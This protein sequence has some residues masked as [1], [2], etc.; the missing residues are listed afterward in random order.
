MTGRDVPAVVLLHALSLD[1]SMWDE[2]RRT[3][4]AR[5][6]QVLAPNQRGFGAVPL[7]DD[8]PSLD[9]LAD[10]LARLLDEHGIG[11]AVVVGASMGGYVAMAFLRRHPD[12]V[13]GLALLSTRATADDPGALAQREAFATLVV[14]PRAGPELVDAA[15]AKLV[16]VTTRTRRPRLL[17]RVRAESAQADTGALAWAQRAIAARPDS[18]DVLRATDVPAVLMVG[19]EDE[20][21]SVAEAGAAAAAL[22][23]GRLVVLVGV[24]HLPPLEAPG[25]VIGELVDLVSRC[26]DV[27]G[28]RPC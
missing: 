18:L 19:D 5:G 26:G 28:S 22:P 24:G 4:R 14:D 12:R 8:P 11:G 17:D 9:I 6:H 3:L 16:G 2:P 21:V 15:A 27:V 25:R 20:L 23:R 7:G 13:R 10:D 1:A